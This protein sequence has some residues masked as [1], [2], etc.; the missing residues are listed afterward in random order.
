MLLITK[1]YRGKRYYLK[2][3]HIE[4]TYIWVMDKDSASNWYTY[5][6]AM[7]VANKYKIEDYKIRF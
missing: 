4:G 3:N 1:I 2:E 5:Q 7:W 6:G